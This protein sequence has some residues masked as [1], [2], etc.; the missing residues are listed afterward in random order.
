M[1][2]GERLLQKCVLLIGILLLLAGCNSPFNGQTEIDWVDF[3]K[4]EGKEYHGIYT[5]ELADEGYIGQEIG[6]IRF[7]V[8][9]NVTKPSYRIKNGDAAFHEKGTRLYS[10]KGHPDLLAVSSPHS[11]NGYQIYYFAP[12]GSEFK[13]HFKDM[14][15]NKVTKIQLY[16]SG[17]RISEWTNSKEIQGFLQLLKNSEENPAFQ[18]DAANGEPIYYEML[19]YTGEPVAYKFDLQFDGDTYFWHPSDISV[20]PEDMKLYIP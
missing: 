14:P 7:M 5:G 8:A 4:W 10:I 2:T 20:L 9:G 17:E 1:L 13:W 16:K 6:T 15:L 18:P 19:F 11:I 3:I 12:E